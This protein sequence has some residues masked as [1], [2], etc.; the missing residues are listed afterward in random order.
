MILSSEVDILIAKKYLITAIIKRLIRVTKGG[1]VRN[2]YISKVGVTP[3][4]I[5]YIR[6]FFQEYNSSGQ[7]NSSTFKYQGL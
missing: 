7:P 4:N 1:K 6:I 5:D 2:Q 3:I